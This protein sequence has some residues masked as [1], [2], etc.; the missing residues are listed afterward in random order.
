MDYQQQ[1]KLER[2]IVAAIAIASI[3]GGL[4]AAYYEIYGLWPVLV[5]C[6]GAICGIGFVLLIKSIIDDSR[7]MGEAERRSK[8]FLVQDEKAE[9]DLLRRAQECKERMG[10]QC[11]LH[12]DYQFKEKHRLVTGEKK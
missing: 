12:P 3:I 10:R 6:G 11:V 4:V 9:S 1:L 2:R 5:A 7:K 8:G